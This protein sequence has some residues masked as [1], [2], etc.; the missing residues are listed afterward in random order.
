MK[1]STK[2][3]LGAIG[4]A[5]LSASSAYAQSAPTPDW[6]LTG[7]FAG[8]SDYR[9]RGISQDAKKAAAQGSLSLTGPDGFYAGTWLSQVDWDASTT[10]DDPQV[11]WDI[12][13]G[14]HFDVGDSTDLNVEAYYYAYPAAPYRGTTASYFEGIFQ[15]SHTFDG[16]ALTGTWAISPQFGFKTGLGNYVEGTAS[17]PL[18]DW[19]SV[20]A[21]VGH[22]WVDKLPDYTHADAGLT[23]TWKS[24]SLDGRYVT[25]DLGKNNCGMYMTTRNACAGGAVLTLTYNMNLLP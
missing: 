2:T 21:N 3:L 22:Q 25:T 24:L 9:F 11:E 13:A 10:V 15:L 7:T 8:Q 4:F 5:A 14:K 1:T 12:F 16:L 23:A 17:F 19:L 20:S 6:S 18:L